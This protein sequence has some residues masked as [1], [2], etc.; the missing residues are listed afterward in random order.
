ME[1]NKHNSQEIAR[2]LS[3]KVLQ[4]VGRHFCRRNL[5][6][7]IDRRLQRERCLLR[8]LETVKIEG[9]R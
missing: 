2:A 4:D 1:A 8:I 7:S 9:G 5:Q 6:R 3:K